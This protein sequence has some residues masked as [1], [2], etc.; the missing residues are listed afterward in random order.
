MKISGPEIRALTRGELSIGDNIPFGALVAPDVCKLRGKTAY[1]ATWRMGGMPFETST[2]ETIGA[3]MGFLASVYRS[4][5]G[6]DLSYW[7]H[8]LGRTVSMALSH[9]QFQGFAKRIDERYTRWQNERGFS[10]FEQYLTLVYYPPSHR[11]KTSWFGRKDE[12]LL[13]IQQEQ[14]AVLKAFQDV[15]YRTEIQLREYRPERLGSYERQG[16]E[17]SQLS[18]FYGF[19]TNGIWRDEPLYPAPLYQT[20]PGAYLHF[21]D[22]NGRMEIARGTER[23]FVGLMEVVDYPPEPRAGDLDAV[24]SLGVDFIETHSFSTLD[25]GDAQST[26]S[27]QLNQLISSEEASKLE[28]RMMEE[29]I[30]EVRGGLIVGG[31]YHFSLALFGTDLKTVQHACATAQ[32]EVSA[33]KLEDSRIVPEGSWYAQLPGNWDKRPRTAFMTSRNFAGLAPF[34]MHPTGKTHGNPWGEAV[35][36]LRGSAGQPFAFNFHAPDNEGDRL[37]AK[38]PGNTVVFGTIGS[39]KTAFILFL[40]AQA[41]RFKPRVL[42]LDKDRGAEIGIRAAGGAYIVFKRGDY[43][44]LNPFQWEDTPATRQLCR[45]MV[46]ACVKR[47]DD[48]LSARAE[49][50]IGVAVD[51][52]FSSLPHDLRRLSAVS[53]FF[54]G[55]DENH[56]AL[57]LQ[58]WTGDGHLAWVLDSPKDTLEIQTHRIFGMDYTV[59]LDDEEICGPVMLVLLALRDSLITGEYFISVIDEFWKAYS[60]K[61]LADDDKNKLKT[62]RKTSMLNI[63]MSQSVSDAMRHE[64]ARTIVEQTPT[65]LY[66]AN[67]DATREDYVEALGTSER[68][69]ELIKSFGQHS[70]RMLIRQGGRSVVVDADLSGLSDELIALSGSL[71]NVKLLDDIR[72]AHGDDPDTWFPLLVQAV[73]ERKERR[74]VE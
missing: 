36:I 26:L 17:Y 18:T 43:T 16:R 8:R 48:P 55:G 37:D 24:M 42:F 44:G 57:A 15:C 38:D 10:L 66:L 63:L 46:E 45:T 72:A 70:R 58:K 2:P 47:G 22:H 53:N 14:D 61:Q 19:L 71:D 41:E 20:L 7:Y 68:E 59:F 11:I 29:A 54:T 27:R 28:L 32:R 74:R 35:T 60:I 62:G 40:L 56:L 25:R 67:P 52:V 49:L 6:G 31:T 23:R 65:K 5:G 69:F 12:D 34:H 4:L 51:T 39:G 33:F 73:N 50:D 3:K 30:E 13:A 1:C 21:G 9:H 64:H